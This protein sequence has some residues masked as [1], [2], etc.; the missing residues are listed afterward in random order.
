MREREIERDCSREM[1]ERSRD[2]SR[3]IERERERERSRE[4]QD[5]LVTNNMHTDIP[6]PPATS[7]SSIGSL[8]MFYHGPCSMV[9]HDEDEGKKIDFL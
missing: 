9:Y 1:F 4:R 8:L 6:L 7:C 5:A 3:E 2:R